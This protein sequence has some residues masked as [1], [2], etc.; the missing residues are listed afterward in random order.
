MK[1]VQNQTPKIRFKSLFSHFFF[2]PIL[3]CSLGPIAVSQFRGK[4]IQTETLT[5]LFTVY[6]MDI[7]AGLFEV[8][9]SYIFFSISVESRASNELLN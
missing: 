9:L 3:L 5:I 1:L 2:L 4:N 8:H 7:P 6:N